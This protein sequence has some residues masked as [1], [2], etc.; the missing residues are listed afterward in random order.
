MMEEIQ[1]LP[2]DIRHSSD[3]GHLFF[4][5]TCAL[6]TICEATIKPELCFSSLPAGYTGA[7]GACE[8]AAGNLGRRGHLPEV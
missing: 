5:I 2:N 1:V 3:I 6:P 4:L 8:K 7:L